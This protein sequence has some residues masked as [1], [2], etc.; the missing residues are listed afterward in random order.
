LFYKFFL[1][2]THQYGRDGRES[3]KID[4][5]AL[6]FDYSFFEQLTHQDFVQQ[7]QQELENFVTQ[8]NNNITQGRFLFSTNKLKKEITSYLWISPF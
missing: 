2:I 3:K 7:L 1:V 5:K 4:S 8:L 6:M